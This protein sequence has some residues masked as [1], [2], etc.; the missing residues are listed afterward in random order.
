MCTIFFFNNFI[1]FFWEWGASF[2]V[3]LFFL[4]LYQ[5]RSTVV[6]FLIFG[7]FSFF[8]KNYFRFYIRGEVR[9]CN[10]A[11]IST[12]LVSFTWRAAFFYPGASCENEM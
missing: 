3:Y 10:S 9:K 8:F 4:F 6:V 11:M 1:Y 7:F 5:L 12:D 2:F